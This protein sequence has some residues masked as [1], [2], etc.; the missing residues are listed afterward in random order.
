MKRHLSTSQNK[1]QIHNGSPS[2]KRQKLSLL[3]MNAKLIQ[4]E[5]VTFLQACYKPNYNGSIKY[6]TI[7]KDFIKHKKSMISNWCDISFNS[8]G[9]L[10]YQALRIAFCERL[11]DFSDPVNIVKIKLN[12][13]NS[14]KSIHSDSLTPHKLTYVIKNS[15]LTS[16]TQALVNKM[17]PI[18]SSKRK[19]KKRIRLIFSHKNRTGKSTKP[20]KYKANP[21]TNTNTNK[22]K[23][24]TVKNDIIQFNGSDC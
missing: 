1:Q 17:T 19:I 3:D 9:H 24:W 14:T 12:S 5:M 2:E 8:H 11:L 7:F 6:E 4:F 23:K 16:N 21:K 10:I 18:Q 13:T 22:M 15:E 20:L